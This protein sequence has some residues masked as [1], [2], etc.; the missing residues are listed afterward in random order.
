MQSLSGPITSS[1]CASADL[2]EGLFQTRQPTQYCEWRN[3]INGRDAVCYCG[4]NECNAKE[5]LEN[6]IQNGGG[7]ELFFII[8]R[9]KKKSKR[10]KVMWQVGYYLLVKKPRV[11]F[12]MHSASEKSEIECLKNLKRKIWTKSSN[13]IVKIEPN[14]GFKFMDL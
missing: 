7:C 13:L 3:G 10:S 12:K 2:A 6:W 9:N 14:N 4:T 1:G 5:I 11:K 8:F